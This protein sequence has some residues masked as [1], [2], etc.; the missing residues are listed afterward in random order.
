MTFL[1]LFGG[2]I[3]ITLLV[4]LFIFLLPLLALISALMSDFP[5]NEKILWVLIILLLPFLGSVLY[6]LIGRN[7]RTN[8]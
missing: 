5:G 2:G 6:F 8:R 1:F 4:I 7:Q 3:I